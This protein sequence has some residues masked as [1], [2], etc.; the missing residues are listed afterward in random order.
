[1]RTSSRGFTLIELLAVFAILASLAA[2]MFGVFSR[3]YK[4]RA[5]EAAATSVASLI[6]SARST[7]LAARD[8]A[9]YGV[10]INQTDA[11]FFKSPYAAGAADSRS[12]DLRPFVQA[13]ATLAG[14]GTDIVFT[15]LTGG[16]P[17]SGTVTLSL[18][19][20]PSKTKTITIE[21]TGVVTVR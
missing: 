18:S 7:T 15:R 16:T 2:G 17:Q 9:S 10:R 12:Y 6:E 20:D 4:N 8:G 1:M 19:A 3:M 13:T 5:L 14:G 21:G 11:V